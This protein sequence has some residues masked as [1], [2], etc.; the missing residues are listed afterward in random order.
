MENRFGDLVLHRD[1]PHRVIVNKVFSDSMKYPVLT[2]FGSSWAAATASDYK[3]ICS[4]QL[5]AWALRDSTGAP[6]ED[7]RVD[8]LSPD[9]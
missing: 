7:G 8:M 5:T 3:R 2:S 1:R 9:R 4:W 6:A